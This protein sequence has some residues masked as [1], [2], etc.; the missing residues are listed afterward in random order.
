MSFKGILPIW[1][2]F[3]IKNMVPRSVDNFRSDHSVS[4]NNSERIILVFAK[5]Y[6]QFWLSLATVFWTMRNKINHALR[7]LDNLL[8]TITFWQK[9]LSL[10]GV[11]HRWMNEWKQ[12]SGRLLVLFIH[13]YFVDFTLWQ[14]VMVNCTYKVMLRIW[15]LSRALGS[16]IMV[17]MTEKPQILLFCISGDSNIW[18]NDRLEHAMTLYFT[19]NITE[20][21]Y[22]DTS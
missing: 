18:Y 2:V 6:P 19:D 10:V 21:T 1:L 13:K 3:Q 5:D 9:F 4:S 12:Y 16:F 11:G 8:P 7:L 22:T 17:G 15:G 20:G 14:R